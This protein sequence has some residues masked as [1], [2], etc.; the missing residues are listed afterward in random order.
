MDIPAPPQPRRE[1]IL[2]LKKLKKLDFDN[3]NNINNQQATGYGKT[4]PPVAEE[5]SEAEPA[6]LKPDPGEGKA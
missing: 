3:N 6:K 4:V 2:H 1:K 5:R